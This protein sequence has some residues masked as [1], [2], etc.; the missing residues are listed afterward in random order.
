MRHTLLTFAALL[1]AVAAGNLRAQTRLLVGSYSEADAPGISLYNFE[2]SDCSVSILSQL[3]GIPNPSYLTIDPTLKHIY[4]VGEGGEGNSTLNHIVLHGDSLLL[5]DSRLTGGA[6]PC[7]VEISPDGHVVST[8]NYNGAS[9]TFF[10]IADDGSLGNAVLK[11]FYGHGVDTLRQSQPHPHSTVY[12][13]DSLYVLVPDLGLDV[14]H[15]MSAD[16][17]TMQVDSVAMAPGSGPRHIRFAPDLRH[18]YLIDEI[19][20]QVHVF[21]YQNGRL[22][23]LQSIAADTVGAQGSADIRISPDGRFV[24]ASNRL[25]ADGI[26]IFSVSPLDGT[27]TSVGYCPTGKH[28]RN[29]VITPDGCHLLVACRDTDA[30]EIYRRDAHTGLLIPTDQVIHTPKPVCLQLF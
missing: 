6:A 23:E 14:I 15:I 22:C 4:A 25:Q 3:S 29:F 30:I 5:A 7:Y 24:Y 9:V 27:L 2:P 8:A 17:S 20:G 18:A 11:Q 19:S 16:G 13:P 1:V 10:P 12:T 21:A 26:A 28:P